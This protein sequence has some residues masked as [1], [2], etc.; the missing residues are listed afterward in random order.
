M[1]GLS[2]TAEK[3]PEVKVEN[4]KEVKKPLKKK[5]S[6]RRNYRGNVYL[7]PLSKPL[8]KRDPVDEPKIDEVP[9]KDETAKQEPKE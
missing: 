1:Q 5:R 7:A 6:S 8:K 3:K 9:T 2:A 4:I